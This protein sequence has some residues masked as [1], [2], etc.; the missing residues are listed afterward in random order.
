LRQLRWLIL[1]FAGKKYNQ[2]FRH[3]SFIVQEQGRT[4]MD[5][6]RTL[7]KIFTRGLYHQQL[8][9]SITKPGQLL[10]KV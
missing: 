4:A 7:Q 9:K 1:I 8:H 6:I 5:F 3:W 2:Q 10:I